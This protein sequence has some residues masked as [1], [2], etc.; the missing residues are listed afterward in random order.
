[1]TILILGHNGLLGNDLFEYN[2]IFK[3]HNLIHLDNGLKWPD[4]EFKMGVE[5]IKCELIINCISIDNFEKLEQVN[6]IYYELPL[7]LSNLKN[8]FVINFT[9]DILN[10]NRKFKSSTFNYYYVKKKAE[11]L[12]NPGF[13][14]NVR[15]SFVGLSNRKSN[16]MYKYFNGSDLI[17][18]YANL[19]WSGVTSLE[20]Y[21]C[22]DSFIEIIKTNK[23]KINF[24][25]DCVSN[26][27]LLSLINE[28]FGFK[29]KIQKV[30]FPYNDSRCSSSEIVCS[31]IKIQIEEL[32]RF[33]KQYLV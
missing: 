25:S 17:L 15:T 14:L 33:K 2:K 19:K 27:E 7:Y 29:L 28:I 20:I 32:Y 11:K 16:L 24:S 1:M 8:V 26:F 13:F 3:K 9:S 10:S 22:I 18:G 21:K 4:L 30:F 23:P 12:S 6:S 5:K 31:N